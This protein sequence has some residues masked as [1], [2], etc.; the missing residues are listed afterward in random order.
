M[1]LEKLSKK[2]KSAKS[3]EDLL[4]HIQSGSTISDRDM[5][6]LPTFGGDEP[7]GT[8]GIFSWDKTRLLVQTHTGWKIV[9]RDEIR[10]SH[11]TFLPRRFDEFL[12][13][14]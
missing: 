13:I 8:L 7:D 6:K 5:S 2:L 9:K 3:L 4:E 1:E 10:Q 14:I 12:E 11:E